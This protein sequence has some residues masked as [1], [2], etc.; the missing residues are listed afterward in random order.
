MTDGSLL[1]WYVELSHMAAALAAN[2]LVQSTLV[3]G[4]GL[5]VAWVLR[6]RGAAVRSSLLRVTLLAVLLCPLASWLLGV[7]GISGLRIGLPTTAAAADRNG[8]APATAS[9]EGEIGG[10]SDRQSAS[11]L[12]VPERAAGGLPG[13]IPVAAQQRSRRPIAA[14]PSDRPAKLPSDPAPSFGRL[15]APAIAYC[16]LTAVW[17]LGVWSLAIRL[18]IAHLLIHRVRRGARPAGRRLQSRCEALADALGVCAPRLLISHRIVNPCLVGWRRPAILLPCGGKA[19]DGH[20]LVHELAHL[21]RRDCLWN[22]AGHLGASLLFF[23]PLLWALRR[24]LA[25]VAEDVCDDYVV[26]HGAE[27]TSYA[28]QLV[29]IA[30]RLQ[31]AWSAQTAGMGVV[32]LKSSLGRRVG[33]ILDTSRGLSIRTGG[34]TLLA[35]AAAGL[36]GTMLVGLIGTRGNGAQAAPVEP[37]AAGTQQRAPAGADGKSSGAGETPNA[38]A[39]AGGQRLVLAGRVLGPDGRPVAGAKLHVQTSYDSNVAADS[40]VRATTAKDGKFRFEVAQSEFDAHGRQMFGR[41]LPIV[42]A[43]E[44]YGPDWGNA[45]QDG[46]ITLRLA[47]DEMAI[48][49][50]LVDPQGQP[51]AGVTINVIQLKTTPEEDLSAWVE[52]LKTTREARP[53]EG[54]MLRKSAPLSLLGPAFGP[55][56]TGPDGRFV[57]RG[58]GRQRMVTLRIEG[59]KI[60]SCVINAMTRAA[61]PVEIPDHQRAPEL[62]KSVYYGATFDHTVVPAKAIVG[63]VRDKDTGKPLAGVTLRGSRSLGGSSLIQHVETTSDARGKY[64][65]TGLPKRDERAV[66]AI[67][68]EDQP[69]LLSKLKVKENPDSQTMT[70]DFQLKRGI[71]IEGRVTDKVT[72]QPVNAA[73]FYFGFWDNPNCKQAPGLNGAFRGWIASYYIAADGVFRRVGLPGHGLIA[74]RVMGD[75]GYRMGMG[76]EGIETGWSSGRKELL[77]TAPYFCVAAN[78]NAIVEINPA[79]GQDP[80]RQDVVLDPGRALRGKVLDP[81]G[82]PLAGAIVNG[83]RMEFRTWAHSP[84]P[85]ATFTVNAYDPSKPRR[86]TFIHNRRRLA[87]SLPVAGDDPGELT[88]RLQPWGVITGRVVDAEGRAREGV[89]L[90]SD[91]GGRPPRESEAPTTGV[92]PPGRFRTDDDGRFRIQGLVPGLQYHLG[93]ME[94]NAKLGGQTFTGYVVRDLSLEPGQTRQLGDVQL[95]PPVYPDP[96]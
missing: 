6:G 39:V 89:T 62:G 35:I 18:G 36:C 90:I 92:L 79:E 60:E 48:R 59:P 58:V 87:G 26:V 42:A 65:L 40:P 43:A 12:S 13:G 32:L 94:W 54:R 80:C 27:R 81:D 44:G 1:N 51:A 68:P 33:R 37:S 7:A 45:I 15:D 23:Q 56:K 8:D 72:G 83:G 31:P 38:A 17:L 69:Y 3:V 20:V 61:E 5:V 16:S 70:L 84:L 73:V 24:R 78:F 96:P 4:T 21:A 76:A 52:A 29:E 30:E 53:P 11:V 49:G 86:L 64:R 28:R 10:R 88:V 77:R 22:L 91:R 41:Y 2:L 25:Q 85:T 14:A 93:A 57:L 71:W 63:V 55:L 9:V 34:R 50:R 47:P 19:V 66:L 82:Q 75:N 46:E 74:V 67:P 95:E